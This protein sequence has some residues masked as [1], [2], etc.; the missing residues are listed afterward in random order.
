MFN[1]ED[2]IKNLNESISKM[3][4]E[5]LNI[6]VT[7][8]E[9][10]DREIIQNPQQ[11][12]YF[13][14]V[15]NELREERAKT[16]ELINQELERVQREYEAYKTKEFN[17]IDGQIQYF[18][19]LLESYATK[20]LQN[21]KKRSIKLPH[22]TLSIKKQQDKYDYDEDAILECLKKNKQDKFI[23]VQTVETVNKKDL[24]K[25]GFSHNG[26]L[27]LDNIE[28]KGVVITA[29]PDKFEIK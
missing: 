2:F 22:G 1:T 9:E 6:N 21:S 3:E 29:Q 16:E 12:N 24:K 13:C 15:V 26:K 14:K 23:R 5:E 10:S 18:S 4:A 11:A 25:E 19:G 28:V 20:E 7:G 17:R 8:N 27:Y